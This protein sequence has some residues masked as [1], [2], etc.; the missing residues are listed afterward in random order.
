[1]YLKNHYLSPEYLPL[2]KTVKVFDSSFLQWRSHWATLISGLLAVVIDWVMGERRAADLVNSHWKRQKFSHGQ[3]KDSESWREAREERTA[4]RRWP[5]D[6]I[7]GNCCFFYLVGDRAS[8]MNEREMEKEYLNMFSMWYKW[9][10]LPAFFKVWTKDLN[11]FWLF[12]DIR[13][14][15]LEGDNMP[16]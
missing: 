12:P 3:E 15:F 1:M 16:R 9:N 5:L 7:L 14:F 2:I 6:R 10:L 8:G 11:G 4:S 13:I